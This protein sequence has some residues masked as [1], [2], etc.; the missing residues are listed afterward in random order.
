MRLKPDW[1]SLLW[2]SRSVVQPT[3]PTACSE[4]VVPLTAEF[5]GCSSARKFCTVGWKP[6]S[7]Y[8][9]VNINVASFRFSV[10][11]THA[12]QNVFLIEF[13]LCTLL[14]SWRVVRWRICIFLQFAFYLITYVHYYSL[15][16]QWKAKQNRLMPR[17]DLKN[18]CS[19]LK[20]KQMWIIVCKMPE[21]RVQGDVFKCLILS[22]SL[23]PKDFIYF[24][25]FGLRNVGIFT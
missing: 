13:D 1:W 3:G 18:I 24:R 6:E 7:L 4:N 20:C 2:C 21:K 19:S 22:D 23:K 17:C 12:Q 10:N 8:I 5:N 15:N 25:G 9:N 14:L 11:Q 16:I